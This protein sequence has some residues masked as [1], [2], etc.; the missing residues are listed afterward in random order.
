MDINIEELPFVIYAFFVLHNFCEL[1][2]ETV[3]EDNLKSEQQSTMI[4]IS[5]Q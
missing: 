4:V 5:S 3:G 1:N 2:H